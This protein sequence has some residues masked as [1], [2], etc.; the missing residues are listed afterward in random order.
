[1]LN[2][3]RLRQKYV[4]VG[5]TSALSLIGFSNIDI[6]T[7][8]TKYYVAPNPRPCWERLAYLQFSN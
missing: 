1:M 5:A 6:D 2:T 3:Q 7:L 8:M 4:I